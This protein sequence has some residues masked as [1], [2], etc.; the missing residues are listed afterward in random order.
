MPRPDI[1]TVLSGITGVEKA[2]FQ[3][4]ESV[5]LMYPCIIYSLSSDKPTYADNDIY[6]N[7]NKYTV[8]VMDK[9]PKSPISSLVRKL[10]Y[11]KF[12]RCFQKDNM[13]HFVYTLYY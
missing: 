2:Y 7:M 10:P 13:N 6:K 11:C 3:P 4:P 1:Q 5:K 12:D 9:N 8:T